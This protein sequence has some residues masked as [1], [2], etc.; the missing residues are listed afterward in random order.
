MLNIDASYNLFLGRLWV[1]RDRVVISILYQLIKFEQ[2]I[3]EVI[4][5]SKGDLSI[6][7]DSPMPFIEPNNVK[8]TFV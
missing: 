2:D 3:K 7:K 4:V 6:N 8:K 1:H 5:H